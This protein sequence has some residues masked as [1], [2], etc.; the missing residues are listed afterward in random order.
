MRN[1]SKQSKRYEDGGSIVPKNQPSDTQFSVDSQATLPTD[2]E[3]ADA[4]SDLGVLLRT[5][6]KSS[7]NK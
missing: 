2:K 7:L 3:M 4:K 5:R 6:A 1:Y